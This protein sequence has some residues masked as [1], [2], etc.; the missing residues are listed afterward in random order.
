MQD[1]Q[2]GLAKRAYP[3][4]DFRIGNFWAWHIKKDRE[5]SMHE[6]RRKLFARA[7]VI[8]PNIGLDHLLDAEEAQI[9]R[10]NFRSF[11]MADIDGSGEI[12]DVPP[13]LVQRIIDEVSTSGDYDDLDRELERFRE[14]ERAGLTDLALRLFEDPFDALQ[15]IKER[16]MPHFS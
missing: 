1:I 7:E 9:V 5:E 3:A 12:K 6:A 15:V 16:V 8:P 13:E 2:A 10:D 14:F 4:E 11:I